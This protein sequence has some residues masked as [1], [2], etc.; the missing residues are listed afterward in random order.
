METTGATGLPG[1]AEILPDLAIPTRAV[2]L[3][4]WT[5]DGATLRGRIFL[6]LNAESH[7]GPETV[8][9]RLNDAD[10][11]ITLSVPGDSGLV[12]VNKIQVIRVELPEE[13][14]L[15][16]ATEGMLEVSLEPIQVRLINGEQLSGTV[17]IHGPAGKCRL[18]DFLNIQPDFLPLQGGDRLHLLHKRFIARVVPQHS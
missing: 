2:P 1:Q 13:E 11:F 5:T 6:R 17:R 10:L 3:T 7:A 18:S 14:G 16:D 12:F 8:Q 4:L 15:P 9:D